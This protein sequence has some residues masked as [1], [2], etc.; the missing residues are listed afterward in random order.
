MKKMKGKKKRRKNEELK[1]KK[2]AHRTQNQN[3]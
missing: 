1:Y 2:R 3:E